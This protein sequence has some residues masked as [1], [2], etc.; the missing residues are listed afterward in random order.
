MSVDRVL[1]TDGTSEDL[2]D[3]RQSSHV[4][5]QLINLKFVWYVYLAS[6]GRKLITHLIDL[7][8]WSDVS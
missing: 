8:D 7:V 5:S 2:R 1:Q 6:F 4:T 3:K